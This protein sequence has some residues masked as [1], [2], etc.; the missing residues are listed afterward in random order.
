MPFNTE[1]I[2]ILYG[3]FQHGLKTKLKSDMNFS[4]TLDGYWLDNTGITSGDKL[5]TEF[6]FDNLHFKFFNS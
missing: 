1:H 4:Y 2:D 6:R 3:V 5:C